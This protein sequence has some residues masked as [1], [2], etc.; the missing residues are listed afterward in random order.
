MHNIAKFIFISFLLSSPL[1]ESTTPDF[2]NTLRRAQN[3]DASAQF[4]LGMMYFN[5]QGVERDFKKAMQWFRKPAERGIT[6]AQ[7][8]LGIMF[9]NGDG[10]P[11]NNRE[12]MAFFLAVGIQNM[13][14]TNK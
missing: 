7:L 12:A 3:G 9:D 1:C 2:K 8:K 10:M 5:G 11:E 14:D 13:G 6:N 4:D